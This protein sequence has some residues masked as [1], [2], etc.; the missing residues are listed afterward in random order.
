MKNNEIKQIIKPNKKSHYNQGFSLVEAIISLALIAILSLGVSSLFFSISS[1]SRLSDEQLRRSAVIR[2]IKENVGTSVQKNTVIVGTTQKASDAPLYDM[3]VE[4][5]SGQE[6]SDYTFDLIK[7]SGV[8][9][10]NQYKITLK[11]GTSNTFEFLFEIC[12]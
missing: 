4:D 8:N 1:I 11:N 12:P 5:L 10:V 9:G 7:N 6:Y 2:I 3:K